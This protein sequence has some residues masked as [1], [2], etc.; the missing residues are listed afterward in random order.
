MRWYDAP[1]SWDQAPE[2]PPQIEDEAEIRVE[3]LYNGVI[4]RARGALPEGQYVWIEK[5]AAVSPG[6]VA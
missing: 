1:E 6:D 5:E 2:D 3:S 4:L